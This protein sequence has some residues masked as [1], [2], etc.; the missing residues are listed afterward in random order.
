MLQHV[1]DGVDLVERYIKECEIR[2]E[3]DEFAHGQTM[4]HHFGCAEPEDHGPAETP[5][6]HHAWGIVGPEVHGLQGVLPATIA[7]PI[8]SLLLV[9]LTIETHRLPNPCQHVLQQRVQFSR[10]FSNRA[11]MPMNTF[12]EQRRSYHQNGNRYERQQRQLPIEHK[13]HDHD[14]NQRQP[15]RNDLFEPVDEDALHVLGIVQHSRHDF[16]R[17]TILVKTDRESLERR[18]YL[19]VQIVDDLLLQPIVQS[20]PHRPTE[21]PQHIGGAQREKYPYQELSLTGLDDIVDDDFD[22]PWR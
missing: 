3:P 5:D 7:L 15:G 18:E 14:P 13:Q 21:V 11:I 17:R 16:A 20:N 10:P 2:N 6:Q 22:Q 19:D 9:G 4:L 1:I 8:E 12:G